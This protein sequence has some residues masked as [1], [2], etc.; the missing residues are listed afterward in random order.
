MGSGRA[1]Q[2]LYDARGYDEP[3]VDEL[4]NEI[5]ELYYVEHLAIERQ[6][7]G[8]AEHL[9]LRHERSAPVV[10]RILTLVRSNV[11]RFDPR[12]SLAK[13]LRYVLNQRE[14]L[15]LFLAAHACRSTTT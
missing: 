3:L 6:I 15:M 5:Q 4:L 11:E 8:S 13:A 12:S 7:V 10:G 9:A 2:Q 14:P 1:T